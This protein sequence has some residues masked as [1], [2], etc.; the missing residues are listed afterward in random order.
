MF[1]KQLLETINCLENLI[2]TFRGGDFEPGFKEYGGSYQVK[3][4][5]KK[6]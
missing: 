1:Q 5:G 6:K 2:G 3:E 4:N